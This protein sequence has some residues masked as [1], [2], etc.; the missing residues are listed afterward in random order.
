MAQSDLDNIAYNKFANGEI[1]LAEYLKYQNRDKIMDLYEQKYKD[2]LE[3][4]R[5]LHD[6]FITQGNDGFVAGWQAAD[7]DFWQQ[8]NSQKAQE[9]KDYL[10]Q[11]ITECEEKHKKLKE[12][13][14]YSGYMYSIPDSADAM[15]KMLKRMVDSC[16]FILANLENVNLSSVEYYE[17]MKG[18]KR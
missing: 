2:A 16:E 1:T 13:L 17:K 8:L 15:F 12:D 7:R 11:M 4:A 10:Q 6:L 14:G 5:A 3:R 9:F 18:G